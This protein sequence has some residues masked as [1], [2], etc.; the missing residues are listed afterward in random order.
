MRNM[1]RCAVWASNAMRQ[2]RAV[3]A[4]N[5]EVQAAIRKLLHRMGR[6][7][8]GNEEA[9]ALMEACDVL[10]SSFTV[11]ER[12]PLLLRLAR[13]VQPLDNE[14]NIGLDEFRARL[15]GTFVGPGEDGD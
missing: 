7:Q 6:T 5:A 1:N 14:M 13:P 10:Q 2:Y 3:V 4:W 15:G 8:R 9:Q 12:A 11:Q